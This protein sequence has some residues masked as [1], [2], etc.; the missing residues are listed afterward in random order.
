M[1]SLKLNL[2]LYR[3]NNLRVYQ[4]LI[5]PEVY[6]QNWSSLL[7]PCCLLG[8]LVAKQELGVATPLLLYGT[9]GFYLA[10][11]TVMVIFY[12]RSKFQKYVYERMDEEIDNVELSD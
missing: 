1:L 6:R 7:Y 11:L 3:Q 12:R 5:D 8:Y 9:V 4:V 2:I 10:T